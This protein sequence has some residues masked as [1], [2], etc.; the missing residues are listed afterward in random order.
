MLLAI[1]ASSYGWAAGQHHAVKLRDLVGEVATPV[2]ARI[3]SS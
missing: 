2:R 3:D 1:V